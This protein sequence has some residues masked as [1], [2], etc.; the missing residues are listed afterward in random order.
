MRHVRESLA[1]CSCKL[2]VS[3]K[4][5]SWIPEV[6][7]KRTGLVQQMRGMTWRPFSLTHA[8]SRTAHWHR[9]CSTVLF[10]PL[11]PF[12]SPQN[13]WPWMTSNDHC[14]LNFHYYEQPFY[15]YILTVM[16]VYTRDQRRCAEADC[17]P[18]NIWEIHAKDSRRTCTKSEFNVS[19]LLIESFNAT[20]FGFN[21]NVTRAYIKW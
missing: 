9:T 3:L 18:H 17:D 21:G 8:R 20:H 5:T 11:S 7:L 15:L 1:F 2:W 12:H 14:T 4:R 16:F 13:T 6:A 10:S 19:W